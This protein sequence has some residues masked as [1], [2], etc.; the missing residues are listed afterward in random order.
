MQVS[1]FAGRGDLLHAHIGK[2]KL[3]RKATARLN[4]HRVM[5]KRKRKGSGKEKKGPPKKP[6]VSSRLARL[7]AS[8]DRSAGMAGTRADVKCVASA[9][10]VPAL[11]VS[12]H[13]ALACHLRAST[14][15]QLDQVVQHAQASQQGVSTRTVETVETVETVSACAYTTHAPSPLPEAAA[16]QVQQQR[17]MQWDSPT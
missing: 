8:N 13:C 3:V 2:F 16:A 6:T 15:P 10:C 12:P 9:L 1:C 17:P 4:A 7:K 5:A 14:E 11:L